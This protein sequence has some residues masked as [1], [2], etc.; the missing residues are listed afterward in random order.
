[1]VKR[2][3]KNRSG[4]TFTVDGQRKSDILDDINDRSFESAIEQ[5]LDDFD[6]LMGK[7]K[8]RKKNK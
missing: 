3:I 2:R 7:I 6:R 8:S 5:D 1:M 4:T